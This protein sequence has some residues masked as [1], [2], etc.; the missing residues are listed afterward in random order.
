MGQW[1]CMDVE[2]YFFMKQTNAEGAPRPSQCQPS[3]PRTHNPQPH[4]LLL[5]R[6]TH[7][8]PFLQIFP[9]SPECFRNAPARPA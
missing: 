1:Q 3:R 7:I 4:P 2:I 9:S 8:P 5:S 6:I